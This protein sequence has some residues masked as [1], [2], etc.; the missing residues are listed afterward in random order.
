MLD[1][2][3]MTKPEKEARGTWCFCEMLLSSSDMMQ[4]KQK[5]RLP[6]ITRAQTR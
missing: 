2:G 1:K 3:Q 4:K 5:T 6:E